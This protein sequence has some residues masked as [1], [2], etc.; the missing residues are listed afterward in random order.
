MK[1]Q[2]INI[3]NHASAAG[4]IDRPDRIVEG[5]IQSVD[6]LGREIAVLLPSGLEVFYV[7]P[8]CPTYLR[9]ERI[10]LRIVQSQDEVRVTLKD[11]C[12][13]VVVKLLE[14]WPTTHRSC[15]Q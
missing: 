12:G 15:L 11:H 2:H 7:P 6:T 10:K 8:D 9:G 14:I 13:I 1:S 5:T 3:S 4:A